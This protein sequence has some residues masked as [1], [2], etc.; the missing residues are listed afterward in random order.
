MRRS[1]QSAWANPVLIGAVT[2]L[3]VM[4]A[5][6][7][8]YNAN[9][10]LPFVPTKELKVNVADGSNIVAGDDV[11][12]GGF[13]IGLVSDLKPIQFSNGVVGAQL[14][15][16]LDQ[17]TARV[18]VDSTA[19]IRPRSVLGLKF[20]DLQRGTSQK[21]FADGATL[22]VSQTSV[23]VQFDDIFKAFDAPTRKAVQQNLV[24]FGDTFTGRGSAVNDTIAG[25]P[26]LLKHLEPV[27]RNLSDPRTGL[28]RF[29]RSLN[30]FVG[31]V[32]PVAGVNARLF[33][34]M[35]TTFGAIARDPN[36]LEA[37]ISESPSTLD[38]STASLKVQQ[39]FLVDTTTFGNLLTPAT[40]EL[41]AA[42]PDIVPAVEV[43]TT[44]LARTPSLNANLQRFMVAL[45]NLAVAP[46]TNIALN[47][48]VS[49]VTILNP[50]IRYL[51]PYVTVCNDWNYWWTY[52]GEHFSEQ[53]NLGFAQRALLN[54]TNAA[55]SGTPTVSPTPKPN[56]QPNSVGSVP[57]WSPV[58]GGG[59][60]LSPLGGNEFLH[61][62]AYGAAID[63][64]GNA[65]CETGQR[66]YPKKLNH[67]DPQGRNLATDPH[68]PGNQGPT[69]TGRARV[70]A[71]Q[72]FSRNPQTGPQ[73]ISPPG[74]P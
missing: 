19:S 5:V 42:L 56:G 65:D 4:V 23:P 68:T 34:D 32:S 55:A 39:P 74:N 10:G 6:F 3:A 49:T 40:A 71:G 15:L 59:S 44:T 26:E 11:R 9:Q 52:L 61:S 66:G 16:K 12:E 53:T 33:G 25:L 54:T 17:N 45:K 57:S 8:A 21:V 7:L 13:R 36:A 31:A 69:W 43:G 47:G 24:G 67:G 38:V 1:Q 64:Q 20:V 50:M 22:P 51:G 73:L 35:A 48:L 2:V 60:D 70:P 30:A 72:T 41:R 62:Q 27:A 14:T 58:N 37:T 29:F 18:P 46:G 28:S 63:N